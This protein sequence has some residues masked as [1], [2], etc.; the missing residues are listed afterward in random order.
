MPCQQ[1]WWTPWNDCTDYW[2]GINQD[3]LNQFGQGDWHELVE[4]NWN[5]GWQSYQNYGQGILDWFSNIGSWFSSGGEIKGSGNTGSL[6]MLGI[7]G[8]LLYKVIK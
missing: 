7:G 6:L 3:D 8:I 1:Y 4:D 2:F 5:Q